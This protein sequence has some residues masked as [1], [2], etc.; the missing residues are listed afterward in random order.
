MCTVHNNDEVVYAHIA[1]PVFAKQDVVEGRGYKSGL[2]GDAN[3]G[4]CLASSH[5]A[6]PPLFSTVASHPSGEEFINRSLL[7][8]VDAQADAEPI[9]SSDSEAT[10][11]SGNAFGSLPSSSSMSIGSPSVPYHIS[12]QSQQPPRPDSPS[13]NMTIPNNLKS[14]SHPLDPYSSAAQSNNISHS[15]YNSMN[16]LHIPPDYNPL[17]S[18]EPDALNLQAKLNGFGPGPFNSRSSVS[19]NPF[20]PRNRPSNVPFR[21]TSAAFN[22][23]AYQQSGDMFAQSQQAQ[24][25]AFGFDTMSLSGRAH[26]FA[27]VGAQSP[28]SLGANG[29]THNKMS[30]SMDG[31]RPGLESLLQS[32]Q[33]N[34][35]TSLSGSLP[36]QQ[37]GSQQPFQGPY[38][39][40][41]L[42]SHTQFGPTLP[43]S[44]A[45]TGAAAGQGGALTG[46]PGMNHVNG[47]AQNHQQE[48]ISTI[49]VVGFPEDMQEREFQNMFTF[50]AGFEA[51]TLKIPNKEFT[52]YG[53]GTN[54]PSGPNARMQYPGS[55]DP[56]NLVTMNQGG[57]VVD[58]G[59]DGQ[60][61]S[62]PAAADD[63]H[64][65]PSN[66]PVQPPRKQIIGF[67]KFRSRQEALE[68]R[69]IL[70][71]RRVDIERGAVLKAEMA[72]KN[73]HTKRGPG[74][75]PESA[76]YSGLNG[77]PGL[78]ANT[79][80]GNTEALAQRDRELGALGAMGITGLGQRRERLG[81]RRVEDERE[82]RRSDMGPV[83]SL[84]A[85]GTR[86]AR[87]RAEEDERERERKRKEHLRLRDNSDAFEAFHS[88]PQQMA[89]QSVNSLLSA[90]NGMMPNGSGSSLPSPP[91]MSSVPS[92]GDGINGLNNGPWTSLRDVGAS[93]ALRKMSAPVF[94]TTTLP[95]RP[96]SPPQYSPPAMFDYPAVQNGNA[97]PG[98]HGAPFSPQ[99]NSSSLPGHPSL[100]TRPRPSSPG[101]E[102]PLQ[103][104]GGAI[105][106]EAVPSSQPLSSASSVSSSQN[107][108]DEELSHSVAALAVNTDSGMTSPQLPS[109]A[110]GASSGRNPGDQ[111]PPINT[112]YVG[113]LP[114]STA[115]GLPLN[116]LEDRLRELFSK[117]PGYRKLCFRQKSNGPM[118]FVEFEDVHYAT[119][120]L[121][122]LYGNTLSGLVKGGGIRLS[123]SKNPLGV[124]TPTSAGGTNGS[125]M[126]QQQSF[127]ASF[128]EAFAAHRQAESEGARPRR[129]TSTMTSPTASYHYT[130]SPPPPRFVSP[131]PSGPFSALTSPN[132]TFP[133]ANSQGFGMAPGSTN[134]FS[135]FGISPTHST[136]PDQSN[137]DGNPD[138]L[139]HNITPTTPNLEPSRAG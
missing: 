2:R 89:R 86:G 35:Q 109:P 51:A 95:A 90:E 117:R 128:S 136:I 52:A 78:G 43:T 108:H 15:M 126:Q 98:N 85:M 3:T 36:L 121:Q 38:G 58:G 84:G 79:A 37:Q 26:D 14:A 103:Q 34:Q 96:S 91:A 65:I 113:N 27:T 111:N 60:T 48:E 28:S 46:G 106:G 107:G 66:L 110:S 40:G 105:A 39:N 54:G 104:P 120:A 124:R 68:A 12:M 73:L 81:D 41:A 82:R 21:D 118:C 88:V 127:A 59:R 57:V 99:S 69:D 24:A 129:D 101:T 123:Y 122:D 49:F 87:E 138:S 56:Y 132:G 13:S 74:V 30:F 44:T 42:P 137:A 114:T 7:D 62:W 20:P 100:P 134:M 97:G 131:P 93:A 67:A 6:R 50:S 33:M 63:S 53:T 112:L 130:T 70:Q 16:N 5:T 18:A 45:G 94:S 72:K 23:V 76:G 61:T 17:T 92:Q 75:P 133:R 9:S 115:G 25:S 22:T 64:F 135:P 10:G 139:S 29:T 102:Q 83:G 55:N 1:G 4:H 125:S 32:Q 71:G 77:P 119:R 80:V 19:F 11:T 8:S 47:A 116:H 31:F